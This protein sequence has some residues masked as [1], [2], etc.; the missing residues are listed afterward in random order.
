MLPFNRKFSIAE[1]TYNN[2]KLIGAGRTDRKEENFTYI[3]TV[4]NLN[5]LLEAN[6]ANFVSI[7]SPEFLA[8]D[9]KWYLSLRRSVQKVGC[10]ILY[11]LKTEHETTNHQFSYIV[12]NE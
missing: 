7:S 5:L 12:R 1:R 2:S 11:L 8:N 9:K 4:T 6:S 10:F 3:W